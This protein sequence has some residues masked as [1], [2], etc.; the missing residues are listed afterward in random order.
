MISYGEARH[1]ILNSRWVS[2][3]VSVGLLDALG[4]KLAEDVRAPID[5]PAFDNSAMDG[6]AV[7]SLEGPWTLHGESAAGS[8]AIPLAAGQACRIFTGAPVGDGAVAVIPQ[9]LVEVADQSVRSLRTVNLGDHVR[10]QGEEHV[11]GQTILL[12]GTKVT[13]PVLAALA[14]MGFCTVNVHSAP[15]AAILVTGSELV[16]PGQPL[17]SG[18]IFESN[19]VGIGAAL[20]MWGCSHSMRAISDDLELTQEA[21]RQFLIDHDILITVGGVSV[22]TYDFVRRAVES[23]GFHIEFSGVAIKPGKPTSFGSREDGKVWLGLPGNPMSALTA[24]CLFFGPYLGKE[25][26]FDEVELRQ[27]FERQSGREE[28]VPARIEHGSPSLLTLLPTIGSHSTHG[29]VLADGLARIPA[30]MDHLERGR[31]LEFAEF[32]WR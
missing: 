3:P 27:G 32:P 28:Y 20:R 1:L 15:R 7:G 21:A 23:L 30:D 29:W 6:Y 13:P 17:N 9:E 25:M 24:L 26:H 16:A 5:S 4:A 2:R 14:S 11:K 10:R 19:S 22:G 12:Q 31:R 18:Q 8:R